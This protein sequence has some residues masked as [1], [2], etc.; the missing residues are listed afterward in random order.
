MSNVFFDQLKI[1]RPHHLLNI[2]GG[3]HGE[4][5]GRMLI[6]IEKALLQEKPDV[7]LVYGDT[8]STLAGAL[9]ASKLHIPVAHVEAGLRSFNMQMPEEV[10]RI[11]TDRLS[12]ILF[13]PT[14]ASIKNLANEGFPFIQVNGEKQII[15]KVGD[16]MQDSALLFARNATPPKD[17]EHTEGFIL[18]T[19]HRAENSDNL[20]R[21]QSILT[22]LDEAAL[23]TPVLIPLHPRTRKI[24]DEPGIAPKNVT[25][26]EP[27]GYLEMLWLLKHCG[28][29]VTDSG[30][31]QKEAYFFGKACV[32][33]CDQTEWV[34]LIEVGANEL[35]GADSDKI[36]A[37]IARNLDR[38][39]D[40]KLQLY[41]G[42]C[43][44]GRISKILE[45][46]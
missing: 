12:S 30:G 35:V 13:C 42:G 34:E 38:T 39:V 20:I 7:I 4:M 14:E 10:N 8:N 45:G 3:N 41:G 2:N 40:D 25:F 1:P 18:A 44:S 26:I 19:I 24:I 31:V 17:A 27:V 46:F 21:L 6:E 29:V 28:L 22:A 9:A 15:E 5:T 11:L 33:M 37:S 36:R 43:A 23:K 32:T 16:V